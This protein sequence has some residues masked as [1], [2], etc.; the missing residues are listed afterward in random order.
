M[1]GQHATIGLRRRTAAGE[2]TAWIIMVIAYAIAFLQRV[3]PQAVNLSLI[4]DFGTNATGVAVLASGY[5]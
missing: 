3:S 2:Y 4:R 5:F 1:S